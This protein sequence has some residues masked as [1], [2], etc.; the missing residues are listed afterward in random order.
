MTRALLIV[1]LQ[2]DFMP[3]GPL[4]V[5]GGDGLA[6]LINTFMEKFP[7]VIA[8]QDWHPQRHVSFASTHQKKVGETVEV[9][10]REQELWPDHC[11]ERTPGSNIVKELERDGI[12]HYIYKGTDRMIDSYSAFFDNGGIKSTGLDTLLKQKGVTELYIAGL[13]TDF[14]VLYSVLDAR[15]LGYPISVIKDA[16]RAIGDGEKALKRMKEAGANIISSADL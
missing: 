10:G 13:A 2:N 16:C 3:G 15:K 5:K 1:D 14:C 6:P 11:V 4:G 7:V 8:T 12:H 9:N